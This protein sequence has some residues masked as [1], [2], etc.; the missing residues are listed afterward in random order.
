MRAVIMF[1][2]CVLMVGCAAN[3]KSVEVKGPVEDRVVLAGEWK[4]V[5]KGTQTG[6]E[7]TVEFNLGMGRHHAEGQVMMYPSEDRSKAQ[8]LKIRFVTV[9]NGEVT[10]KITPYMDPR[11]KCEV[12]TE[13]S[14]HLSGDSIEGSFVTHIPA[15]S[16]KQSGTWVVY[17]QAKR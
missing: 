12:R 14:G 4:G 15:A 5:F 11:C 3:G 13:F 2:M 10:G 17:R 6:R 9:K 16:Q 7:G 8:P 1:S